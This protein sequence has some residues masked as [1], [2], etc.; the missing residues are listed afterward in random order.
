M[1]RLPI[2]LAISL[3]VLESDPDLLM[4][5]VTA[6]E[7]SAETA[8]LRGFSILASLLS[9]ANDTGSDALIDQFEGE[10]VFLLLDDRVP[11]RWGLGG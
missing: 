6:R 10:V 8:W 2:R 4:A 1:R 5:S 7:P 11:C 9:V 3:A